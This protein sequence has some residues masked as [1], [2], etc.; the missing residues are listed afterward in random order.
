MMSKGA[1]IFYPC[2]TWARG[3]SLTYLFNVLLLNV[4]HQS[5]IPGPLA[6]PLRG[7]AV[8][9]QTVKIEPGVD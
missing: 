1:R 8:V 2:T 6:Q 4:G 7:W 5:A 3:R 9:A